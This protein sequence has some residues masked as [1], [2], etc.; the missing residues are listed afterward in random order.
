MSRAD[1]DPSQLTDEDLGTANVILTNGARLYVDHA[2]P[3]YSA[4]ECL[5][6]REAA[7]HDRAGMMIM[8]EAAELASRI[9]GIAPIHLYKNNTDNKG[10]SYG[11]H[12]NYLMSRVTPFADV[13]RLFTAFLV[14]RQV[15]TG[16]GRLGKHARKCRGRCPAAGHALRA[17]CCPAVVARARA[18][19]NAC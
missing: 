5:T 18:A 4:P 17:T 16:A 15:F 19:G 12:E 8:A 13:V 1:A 3:E 2:H 11:C 7:L 14:T 9:P 10:A 6:P